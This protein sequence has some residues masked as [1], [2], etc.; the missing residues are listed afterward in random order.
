MKDKQQHLDILIS[1]QEDLKSRNCLTQKGIDYL[2]GLKS[3][4]KLV[5]GDPVKPKIEK[6]KQETIRHSGVEDIRKNF[7]LLSVK[8][9]G[10]LSL[11][12]G[13][14]TINKYNGYR[15]ARLESKNLTQHF[16]CILR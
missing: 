1:S 2:E 14:L 16:Y 7:T 4:R 3:A 5:F 9:F 8:L 6:V 12:P 13:K 11:R 10:E 15:L